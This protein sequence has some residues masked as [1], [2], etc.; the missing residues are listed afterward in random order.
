MFVIHTQVYIGSVSR[1]NSGKLR[2]TRTHPR[3]SSFLL[4]SCYGYTTGSSQCP[5][6]PIQSPHYW[7][8]E[9]RK[10][11]HPPESL[12]HH[13]ESR[14]LQRRFIGSSQPGTFS[15]LLA[16]SISSSSQVQLSPTIEVG[17][18]YFV[19]DADVRTRHVQ[20]G[21][22]NIEHELMFSSH[23]GYVFHDSRGFEGG[24][25]DELK[26]VQDFVRQRSQ[27]RLLK[28]RLHAIWCVSLDIFHRKFTEVCVSGTAFRWTVLGHR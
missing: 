11:L 7:E 25:E 8:S 9:R 5:K 18:T 2:V 13:R 4:F 14:D 10:N 3:R 24:S 17:Q 27:E 15:L 23:K 28:D 1:R 21:E 20:R 22:H 26:A 12:R 19:R 6:C 16:L